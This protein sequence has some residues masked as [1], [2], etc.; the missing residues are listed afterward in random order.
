MQAFLLYPTMDD[1]GFETF[2][3]RKKDCDLV[4][5]TIAN[6]FGSKAMGFD[7]LS[8]KAYRM[9]AKAAL[10]KIVKPYSVTS[11]ISAI[12]FFETHYSP[13][14]EAMSIPYYVV[15]E[16]DPNLRKFLPYSPVRSAAISSLGRRRIMP[17]TPR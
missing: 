14:I 16:V 15:G 11:G 8:D 7:L 1:L 2:A 5:E 3:S 4:Q 6:D 10:R 17:K 9:L 13:L 12:S